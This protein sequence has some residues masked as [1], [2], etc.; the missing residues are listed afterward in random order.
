MD[1]DKR[2]MTLDE[3]IAVIREI[4][5]RAE[6]TNTRRAETL[7][8]MAVHD[9]AT[10]TPAPFAG[11]EGGYVPGFD[12]VPVVRCKECRHAEESLVNGHVYCNE[13][14]RARTEDGFCEWGAKDG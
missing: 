8:L 10:V 14:E 12:V 2:D 4:D 7:I 5:P 6:E 11:Y 13:M 3:A 1:Y 9:G